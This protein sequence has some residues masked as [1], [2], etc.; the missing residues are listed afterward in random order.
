[1]DSL[2][3]ALQMAMQTIGNASEAV[4][5]KATELLPLPSDPLDLPVSK[6]PIDLTGRLADKNFCWYRGYYHTDHTLP[7]YTSEAKLS[8]RRRYP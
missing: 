1:M 4:S 3:R 8:D 7:R 5:G 6:C 2:T